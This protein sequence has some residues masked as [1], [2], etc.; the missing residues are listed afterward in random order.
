M[1]GVGTHARVSDRDTGGF[2]FPGEL[3]R[4]ERRRRLLPDLQLLFESR[5]PTVLRRDSHFLER[6]TPSVDPCR[7]RSPTVPLSSPFRRPSVR[8]TKATKVDDTK[9]ET[10]F[11]F[12]MLCRGGPFLDDSASRFSRFSRQNDKALSRC[13]ASRIAES[14]PELRRDIASLEFIR[15]P[16]YNL[17]AL[18]RH[19]AVR[20]IGREW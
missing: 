14:S 1:L 12:S 18:R 11:S 6:L 13:R 19:D 5:R 8:I 3:S 10:R 7:R 2:R 20:R 16:R 4:E 15:L 17:G 9:V